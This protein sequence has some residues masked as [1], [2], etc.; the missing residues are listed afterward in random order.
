MMIATAVTLAI[1]WFVGTMLG[2]LLR[3]NRDKILAALRG[4]SFLAQHRSIPARPVI[5][6]FSSRFA[7]AESAMRAPLRAAA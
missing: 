4:R 1:L 2:E 5:V 6:R 7:E 3:Q